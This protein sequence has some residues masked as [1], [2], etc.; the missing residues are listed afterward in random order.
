[1]S[2]GSTSALRPSTNTR[3]NTAIKLLSKSTAISLCQVTSVL[4]TLPIPITPRPGYWARPS[5]PAAY[6]TIMSS[7]NESSNN[8]LA[9]PNQ[10]LRLRGQD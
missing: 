6:Q 5:T 2:W 4:P 3:H 7:D 9:K 1:M 8:L 10:L